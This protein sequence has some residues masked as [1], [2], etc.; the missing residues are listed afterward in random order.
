MFAHW[1]LPAV[2]LVSG[3]GTGVMCLLVLVAVIAVIGLVQGRGAGWPGRCWKTSR[4]TSPSCTSN[5]SES[6]SDLPA[7][8]RLGSASCG[9]R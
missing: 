3:S 6:T 9:P 4:R 8:S 2:V 1:S 7:E 5:Y